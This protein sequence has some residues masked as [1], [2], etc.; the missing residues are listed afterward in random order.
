[1]IRGAVVSGNFR[2]A[3]IDLGCFLGSYSAFLAHGL[4][5]N[6]SGRNFQVHSFDLLELGPFEKSLLPPRGEPPRG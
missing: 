3:I 2:R 6:P 1:M 5:R 4:S